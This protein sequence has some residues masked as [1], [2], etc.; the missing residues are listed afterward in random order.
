MYER[1]VPTMN[2]PVLPSTTPSHPLQSPESAAHLLSRVV[3]DVLQVREDVQ[4]LAGLRG[5]G[6]LNVAFVFL[7]EVGLVVVRRVRGEMR[8]VARRGRRDDLGAA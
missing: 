6:G 3:Q 8:V 2:T 7:S 1:C 4:H 5:A